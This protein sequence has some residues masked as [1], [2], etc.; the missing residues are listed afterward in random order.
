MEQK[1]V[2]ATAAGGQ[3]PT[4]GGS[5]CKDQGN[6]YRNKGLVE[7]LEQKKFSAYSSFSAL[8]VPLL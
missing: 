2:T 5:M 3:Y 8:A 1:L 6:P 7:G 4:R